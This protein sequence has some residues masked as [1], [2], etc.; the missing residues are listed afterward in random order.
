MKGFPIFICLLCELDYYLSKGVYELDFELG[1]DTTSKIKHD[2]VMLTFNLTGSHTTTNHL[3]N[4]FLFG[5]TYR[6]VLDL[7]FPVVVGSSHFLYSVFP[8]QLTDHKQDWHP[9]PVDVQY[10][11]SYYHT[12]YIPGI[13]GDRPWRPESNHTQSFGGV[14]QTS[15][16]NIE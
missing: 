8:L 1:D 12:H 11:K 10:V 16:Y 7:P 3:I 5:T 14:L 15:T 13:W 4:K 2:V 6:R 9:Y